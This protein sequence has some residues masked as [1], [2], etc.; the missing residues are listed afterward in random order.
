MVNWGP[1]C[2]LGWGCEGMCSRLLQHPHL[3]SRTT[4]SGEQSKL[5]RMVS[6]VKLSKSLLPRVWLCPPLRSCRRWCLSIPKLLLP[7]S[8]Q[9]QS[10]HQS[11]TLIQLSWN[12]WGHFLMAQPLAKPSGLHPSHLRE[13]T[14]CPS[15]DCAVKKFGKVS[16]S[17]N[18]FYTRKFT[19]KK[20]T[21]VN[22]QECTKYRSS[23]STSTKKVQ[24]RHWKEA[25]RRWKK[26]ELALNRSGL[27]IVVM[28]HARIA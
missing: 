1:G 17:R 27:F 25:D 6:T 18:L 16:Q 28:Q 4:R 21:P 3:P 8:H 10:Y 24:Y 20:I 19:W 22:M 12:G 11:Y 26:A 23:S 13:G 14:Y 5:F 2:P 15:P 7:S 9:I